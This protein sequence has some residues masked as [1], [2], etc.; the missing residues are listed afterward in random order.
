MF[1]INLKASNDGVECPL[2]SFMVL[3][4]QVVVLMNEK[5]IAKID[6]EHTKDDRFWAKFR[7]MIGPNPDEAV[8]S[9]CP[10]DLEPEI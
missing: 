8:Y 6:I 3:D 10:S 9:V 2:L 7:F 4:T 1:F 5:E